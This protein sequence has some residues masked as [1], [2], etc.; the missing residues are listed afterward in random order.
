MLKN[1]VT[2]LRKLLFKMQKKVAINLC[3]LTPIRS[4]ET[5]EISDVQI[6]AKMPSG[7]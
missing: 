4:N 6:C 2:Y 3:S 7:S 1:D 5:L